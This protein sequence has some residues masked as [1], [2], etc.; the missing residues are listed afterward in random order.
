MHSQL[1]YQMGALIPS[2][3]ETSTFSMIEEACKVYGKFL[4]G[5]KDATKIEFARWKAYWLRQPVERRTKD[6]QEALSVAKQL[7][8]YP[9]ITELLQIFL[10]L[11]VT[12]A[13]GERAFSALKYIKTYLR[14]TMSENRLNGLAH[15][16][17]NKDI[18]LNYNDVVDE[19][20]KSNHRLNFM[21]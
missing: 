7:G 18:D 13:T 11:P 9:N 8:T 2:F 4:D 6:I 15:L 20:S 16:F 14:S 5:D 17:I 12:T 3:C 10:V 21:K 1:A 19:F